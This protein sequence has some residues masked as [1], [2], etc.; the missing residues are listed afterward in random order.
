MVQAVD[1]AYR[2]IAELGGLYRRRELSPVDLLDG[3][4][5]VDEGVPR[6]EEDG[7]DHE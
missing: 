3:R 7:A 6:V 2:S 1:V 4:A 5:R